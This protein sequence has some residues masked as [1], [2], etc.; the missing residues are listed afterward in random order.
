MYWLSADSTQKGQVIW[1]EFP[2]HDIIM[3][4]A[5]L[6]QAVSFS[7]G[8]S[9]SSGS[10]LSSTDSNFPSFTSGSLEAPGHSSGSLIT[11]T[12]KAGNSPADFRFLTFFFVF[13][14]GFSVVVPASPVSPGGLL[15]STVFS[16]TEIAVDSPGTSVESCEFLFSSAMSG[17][18]WPLECFDQPNIRTNSLKCF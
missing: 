15:C 10:L 18:S 8:V 7:P 14:L 16:G 2:C 11:G 13:F 12:F 5:W 9:S 17:Q 1:K 4:T 3:A 6:Q